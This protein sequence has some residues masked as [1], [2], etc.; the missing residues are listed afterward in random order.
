[1][2]EMFD[3]NSKMSKRFCFYAALVLILC[4]VGAA[5]VSAEN[6]NLDIKANDSDGPITVLPS[7]PVSIQISLYPG[8][9]AGVNDYS[10]ISKYSNIYIKWSDL[11]NYNRIFNWNILCLVL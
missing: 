11:S 6:L 4:L 1:M 10:P 2:K 9:Q 7:D 3:K 8:D 5:P